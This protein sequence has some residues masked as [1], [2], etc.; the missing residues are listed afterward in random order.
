MASRLSEFIRVV[1][2][3]DIARRYFVM[4]SFDGALTILGIIIALYLTDVA[5][6]RI[7]LVS[8]LGAAVAMGVSGFFGAYASEQAE[9]KRKFLDLERHLMKDLDGT[10]VERRMKRI[11]VIIA[12]VDGLS[13]VIVSLIIIS[14][15]I[16]RSAGGYTVADAYLAS[17]ALVAAILMGLGAFIGT[18][19][20]ESAARN[21]LKMLAAGI[22]VTLISVGLE[23]MKV[24]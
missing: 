9:R 24:I 4:N 5:S 23:Y 8:C 1:R 20:K 13:P 19:A 12:L 6:A 11:I 18:I 22:I 10:R 7:I 15:F 21:A 17:F 3:E 16:L 14:P 2:R